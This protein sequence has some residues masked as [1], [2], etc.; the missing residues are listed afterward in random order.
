MIRAHLHYNNGGIYNEFM[1]ATILIK[2]ILDKSEHV[3]NVTR[4]TNKQFHVQEVIIST[5]SV[6]NFL[7][8]R[9]KWK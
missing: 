2:K 6:K 8:D 9:P 4:W 1:R 3:I 5:I 7:T